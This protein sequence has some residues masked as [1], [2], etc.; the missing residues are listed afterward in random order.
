MKWMVSLAEG[1]RARTLRLLEKQ[2]LAVAELC[3][4]LQLPQSTVSRHLK[5]LHDDGWIRSR[6]EGTSRFYSFAGTVSGAALRL[7]NILRDEMLAQYGD[8]DNGEDGLV[9]E[10]ERLRRVLTARQTRSKEFFASSADQWDRLREE[11]FGP[12]LHLLAAASLL[13]ET[14]VIGDLGCGTGY[15]AQALSPF[16]GR[17]IAI[18]SSTAML[19]AA[20]ERTR[21]L[22]NVEVRQGEMELLPL[23]DELLDAAIAVLVLHHLAEPARLFQEMARILKP[24]GKAI[25]VD[26][27]PHDRQEYRQQMGHVWLGFAPSQIEKWLSD[28]GFSLLRINPLSPIS[29]AKGPPLFFATAVRTCLESSVIPAI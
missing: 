17:I 11:M 23:E 6:R 1:T 24:G 2:E 14:W 21:H 5:V 28:A 20:R 18:D 13:D 19:E 12:S 7:W 16:L 22:S 4:I 25:V 10:E 29:S 3:D 9:A 8:G 26:M 27:Q 15:L